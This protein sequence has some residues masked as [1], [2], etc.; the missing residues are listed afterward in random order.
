[1][2]LYS[3]GVFHQ[4][5]TTDLIHNGVDWETICDAN[6][7]FGFDVPGRSITLIGGFPGPLKFQHEID[8]RNDGNNYPWGDVG[9]PFVIRT[10]ITAQ[11]DSVDGD[12]YIRAYKLTDAVNPVW[13]F[14][15]VGP[16]GS[17]NVVKDFVVDNVFNSQ[18][19]IVAQYTDGSD[20]QLSTINQ[21]GLVGIDWGGVPF[22]TDYNNNT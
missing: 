21:G 17:Y 4:A 20:W 12:V 15:P 16:G 3:G 6:Y 9:A 11:P 10:T 5:K 14:G 8:F 1:M 13:T 19:R 7:P 18:M 22:P 2:N